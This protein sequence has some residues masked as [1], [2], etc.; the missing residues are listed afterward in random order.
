[1]REGDVHECFLRIE[2]ELHQCRIALSMV[3][4]FHLEADSKSHNP[5]SKEW[6]VDE[7]LLL[8]RCDENHEQQWLKTYRLARKENPKLFNKSGISEGDLRGR[9]AELKSSSSLQYRY[10][11][12]KK[13][14]EAAEEAE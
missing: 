9:V 11:L 2:S 14:L 3:K 13:D 10:K 7:D 5:L 8:L 4:N 1:M 12:L 6:S